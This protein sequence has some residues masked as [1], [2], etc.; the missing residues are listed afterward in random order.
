MV[1][2]NIINEIKKQMLP[3]F[4]NTLI[5]EDMGRFFIQAEQNGKY[6]KYS[7]NEMPFRITIE[8]CGINKFC[9]KLK[10]SFQEAFK[11]ELIP[12]KSY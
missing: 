6:Q 4:P 3:E 1:N 10:F 7:E 8:V 12:V 9:E 5:F 11:N 2:Q